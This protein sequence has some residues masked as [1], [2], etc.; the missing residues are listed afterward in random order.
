MLNRSW[1]H[2]V[3]LPNAELERCVHE[4]L[5]ANNAQDVRPIRETNLA[6]MQNKA[7]QTLTYL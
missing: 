1:R 5:E 2:Q 6:L 7:Q 3:T 4:V